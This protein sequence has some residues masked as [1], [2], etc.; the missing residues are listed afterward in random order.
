MARRTAALAALVA[1]FV[2][3]PARSQKGTRTEPFSGTAQVTAVELVVS[4]EDR[5][6]RLPEDLVPADFEVLEDGEPVPVIA[7]EIWRRGTVVRR[8]AEDAAPERVEASAEPLW[9]WHTLIYFDQVL[10]AS[11]S[12]RRTAEA[13]AAQAG[14]LTGLGTVEVVTANPVAEQV[15]APTRSAAL[16]EQ[17]LKRVARETVGRDE[18]RQLR[19][20]LTY[21]QQLDGVRNFRET[22]IAAAVAQESLLLR[23]Q[24]D[25]LMA[26]LSAE[27]HAGPRALVL[28]ND[29]YDLS[30]Q[31]FYYRLIHAGEVSSGLNSEVAAQGAQADVRE[32][33]RALAASGWVTVSLGLGALD[34]GGATEAEYSGRSRLGEKDDAS[35]EDS[36]APAPDALFV[37]P[38]EPLRQV[39]VATGGQ[40][41]TGT[42]ELPAALEALGDK[43]RLTYQVARPPDGALR[44][45]E[46]RALRPGLEVTAPQWAGSVPPEGVSAARA[47]R[48]LAGGGDR[49]D[50]P[51]TA[52]VAL[53]PAPDEGAAEAAPRNG[54]LQAR[55]DLRPL[56]ASLVG[57][58]PAPVRV[59][60]AASLA[61]GEPFVR[62]DLVEGQ[63]LA[64]LE[65]WTYGLPITLP[66]EV[67]RVSVVFEELT[68][69]AWGGAV[70][71]MVE[72]PLP[73]AVQAAG[74][75]DAVAGAGA[76]AG[77]VPRDL[78]PERKA[79]VLPPPDRTVVR[80]RVALEPLIGSPR[81]A[82]VEYLL[83]G[84]PA[85]TSDRPPFAARIDF[86]GLPAPHLVEAVG[87]DAEGREIGRD[88]LE[89]NEGVG[90]FRVRIIEPRS[91]DRVGAV[92]VEA[93]VNVPG[94]AERLD[95]VEVSW[96]GERVATLYQPPF[97]S[98]VFVPPDAPVGYVSV[99][100][101]RAD[102]TSAEDLVFLNGTGPA[103]RV[104]VRLVELF[105]V[106]EDPGQ[107][108]VRGLERD[109]F[110]VFEDGAAQSLADFRDGAE[111]PLSIGLV[112]DT[113]ASMTPALRAAQTAAIDFL[114]LSLRGEQDRALVVG[115]DAR[116]RLVQPLTSSR[117]E[118]VDAIARL[119]AGGTSALC[120]ALVFA[121][122]Q[123]QR[124]P[125]RRALVVLTDGVGR[126]ER[127]DYGTCLRFV[128]RNGIP[129]YAILLAGDDPTASRRGGVDAGKLEPLVGSVGGRLYVAENASRLGGVY[130][131]VIEEL[132]SQYL[133]TYY[134][135][136]P[137]SAGGEGWR[138]V[139][140][141]VDR[142]GLVARTLAGYYP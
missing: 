37:R 64:G 116:P 137:P 42:R 122:V 84:E 3:T 107:H 111:M 117:D 81:I 106:V 1:L 28:V 104:D 103:E 75:S 88:A 133:L 66:G 16:V 56:Q 62:H 32:L 13:L 135:R 112:I 52:A 119:R 96:N 59:T 10:S 5:E 63:G 100:A 140:V 99:V 51:V 35:R 41:L 6:G 142:A 29:G 22:R 74:A 39:A 58:G 113:S 31:E 123:M 65:A 48:L 93:E 136:R 47:R 80:G 101:H 44:A 76:A 82:R 7:V 105:T 108:P 17:T 34:A 128:Q 45:V 14:R 141:E 77:V 121:L 73:A 55:V 118:L 79:I 57:A 53:E 24:H 11:R 125:G 124:V 30:P 46:V 4:V 86:G 9:T 2:A 120:D 89:V 138:E 90:S 70:A 60:V 21:D 18:L 67:E 97:R 33:S 25:V 110:R 19:R 115:F 69:G 85:A 68:T 95:R 134:P 71:A 130:R 127:V 8:A 43:V 91:G 27:Q 102:G 54:K 139:D 132:R 131:A 94:G 129:V 23:R 12:I 126:E 61:G 36:I 98:R 15:L 38:I 109:D 92:D 40:V 114:L 20:Q 83:D 26:R 87:F 72:G 49:G 50:L 78:L